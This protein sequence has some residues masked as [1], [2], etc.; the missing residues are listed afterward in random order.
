MIE[1]LKNKWQQIKKFAKNREEYMRKQRSGANLTW[2]EKRI[3]E[4]DLFAQV[5]VK[6]G[7]VRNI[8]GSRTQSNPTASRQ[9]A[10]PEPST[11]RSNPNV[12]RSINTNTTRTS[13]E[14]L[15]IQQMQKKAIHELKME[16]IRLNIREA[17]LKL[18]QLEYAKNRDKYQMELAKLELER[19][20]ENRKS[21]H[22]GHS[23]TVRRH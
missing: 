23:N 8:D 21:R 9:Q 2:T 7:F 5:A 22:S 1:T 20:K 17:K 12:S 3:V 4:S 13:P 14:F 18:E 10:T 15:N 19:S 11:S 6:L 16:Q